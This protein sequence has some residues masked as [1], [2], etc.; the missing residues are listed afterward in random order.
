[1][2]LFYWRCSALSG[3]AVFESIKIKEGKGLKNLIS[4]DGQWKSLQAVLLQSGIPI[5]ATTEATWWSNTISP[6]PINDGT[7]A[8]VLANAGAIYYIASDQSTSGYYITADKISIVSLNSS[9]LSMSSGATPN[10]SN[11]GDVGTDLTAVLCSNNRK[12]TWLEYD[13]LN[14]ASYYYMGF[15]NSFETVTNSIFPN[16]IV[17]AGNTLLISNSTIAAF[18]ASPLSGSILDNITVDSSSFNTSSASSN[19][20][21]QR[22]KANSSITLGD[23]SASLFPSRAM[24]ISANQV[25]WYNSNR[26][27]IN[28]ANINFFTPIATTNLTLSNIL[29]SFLI[30]TGSTLT[31]LTG[32][33]LQPTTHMCTNPGNADNGFTAACGI[34]GASNATIVSNANSLAVNNTNDGVLSNDPFVAGSICPSAVHGN[35]VSKNLESTAKTY[36]SNAFEILGDEIGNDNG[37][38]ESN[39]DCIYTPNFGSYQGTGDFYSNGTCIFQN[40]T[41]SGVQMYAYPTQ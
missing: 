9:R 36:L 12:F 16:A 38:C 30:A 41:I 5:K 39:E 37:L 24:A 15:S 40:G 18:Y 10:C 28:N 20:I 21:Y 17:Y 34:D 35:K 3:H 11:G 19:N 7:G 33:W 29:T 14:F 31:K 2:D 1:M 25:N 32:L 8:M 23:W 26:A 27:T 22:I 4:T 6:L 13:S